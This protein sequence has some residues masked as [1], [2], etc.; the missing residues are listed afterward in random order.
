MRYKTP[1]SLT[2][3]FFFLTL[4]SISATEEPEAVDYDDSKSG[5]DDKNANEREPGNAFPSRVRCYNGK[6]VDDGC[7]CDS[8]FVGKFCH[9]ETHCS[10][11]ER[12]DNNT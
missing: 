9:L 7:E 1:Y 2:A 8:N 11:Y 10:S 6:R 3:L 4:L 12:H 5:E